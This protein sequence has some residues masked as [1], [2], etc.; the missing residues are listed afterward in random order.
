MQVDIPDSLR[1]EM[2]NIVRHRVGQMALYRTAGSPE[3]KA[4]RE[5]VETL[6][7]A[8][9]VKRENTAKVAE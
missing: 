1:V 2:F 7:A 3:L 5:L 9:D 6:G 8:A 4:L